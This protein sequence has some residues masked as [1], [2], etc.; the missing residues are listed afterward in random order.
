MNTKFFF[1]GEDGKFTLLPKNVNFNFF[2][3][4]LLAILQGTP[5]PDESDYDD[6][7]GDSG[8][9]GESSFVNHLAEWK[10][11]FWGYLT[12][13]WFQAEGEVL[14][15]APIKTITPTETVGT[16]FLKFKNANTDPYCLLG[17]E[18]EGKT[19]FRVNNN[20]LTL[21]DNGTEESTITLDANEEYSLLFTFNA[22]GTYKVADE[23]NT[24]LLSG[25]LLKPIDVSCGR[26][27]YN[28]WGRVPF[29]F[30]VSYYDLSNAT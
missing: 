7:G 9:G 29:D 26:S 4:T 15:S 20:V 11:S 8:G 1:K 17:Y 19:Y 28:N 5:L 10:L 24:E 30:V 25:T 16:V 22:D 12:D 13:G 21:A 23:Q 3:A 18:N 27:T 2:A 6:G 14:D